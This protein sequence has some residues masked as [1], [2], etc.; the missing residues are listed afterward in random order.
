LATPP[1]NHST[2]DADTAPSAIAA[3][4]SAKSTLP[5]IANLLMKTPFFISL[6]IRTESPVVEAH[7]AT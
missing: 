2:A 5:T 6:I 4:A 7:L 3:I 1:H